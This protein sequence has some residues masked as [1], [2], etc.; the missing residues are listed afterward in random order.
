VL[1]GLGQ[2]V[3]EAEQGF[4]ALPGVYRPDLRA[5]VQGLSDLVAFEERLPWRWSDGPR[6]D[7]LAAH[8]TA[9]R[10]LVGEVQEASRFF[11]QIEQYAAQAKAGGAPQVIPEIIADLPMP[12]GGAATGSRRPGSRST[13][14]FR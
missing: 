6:V 12:T 9:A 1:A 8:R 5:R 14:G 10:E 7:R 13:F 2:E 4:A 3:R 11:A